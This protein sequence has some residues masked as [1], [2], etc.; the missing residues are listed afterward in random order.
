[1]KLD[2]ILLMETSECHS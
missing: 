2:K 1:M